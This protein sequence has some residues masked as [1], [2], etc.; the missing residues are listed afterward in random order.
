MLSRLFLCH[1]ITLLSL[2]ACSQQTLQPLKPKRGIWSSVCA[3]HLKLYKSVEDIVQ[4]VFQ[5]IA[6]F[7]ICV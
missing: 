1:V 6:N 7:L 5:I 3:Q 2:S 4:L